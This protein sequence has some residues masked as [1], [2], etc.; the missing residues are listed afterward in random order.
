MILRR[1]ATFSRFS[2]PEGPRSG[3]RPR[4]PTFENRLSTFENPDYF[5]LLSDMEYFLS[6]CA[7]FLKTKGLVLTF[8]VSFWS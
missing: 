1:I 7:I 5:L 2:R 3:V 8:G 6:L 4:R